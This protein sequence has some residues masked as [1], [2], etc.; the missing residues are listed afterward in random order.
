MFGD[1]SRPNDNTRPGMN[2][3]KPQTP[4]NRNRP[5]RR[6]SVMGATGGIEPNTIQGVAQATQPRP[7]P[8]PMPQPRPMPMQGPPPIDPYRGGMNPF[9]AGVMQNVDP[10]TGLPTNAPTIPNPATGGLPPPILQPPINIQPQ[11]QPQIGP[12]SGPEPTRIN[13][14]RQPPI[15]IGPGGGFQNEA[16]VPINRLP[17]NSPDMMQMRRF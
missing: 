16:D 1:N 9:Q 14:M 3:P 7:I 17:L 4:I 11:I 5:V 13:P 15:Q 12:L 6:P 8:Q 2:K 10:R